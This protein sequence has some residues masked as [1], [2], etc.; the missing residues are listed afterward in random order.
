MK[1]EFNNCQFDN[2]QF[3]FNEN[4]KKKDYVFYAIEAASFIGLILLVPFQVV[5]YGVKAISH[6]RQNHLPD[7]RKT[8]N[9]PEYVEYEEVGSVQQLKETK[10]IC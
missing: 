5:A 1:T 9:L 7:S 2:C 6:I 8:I 3:Q 4:E 10:K